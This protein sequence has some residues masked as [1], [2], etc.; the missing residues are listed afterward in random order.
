[1]RKGMILITFAW[2]VEAIGVLA[3]FVTAVITTY[4]SGVIP[5][6]IWP[7]LVALP[8]GMI[9]VAELGRIPLTSVL[10]SRHKVMQVVALLGIL[11]LAGLAFENW[12]FG[13]E[14]I[15]QLR[16]ESVTQ[17]ALALSEAQATQ[18]NLE[19]Q[20]EDIGK[21]DT[22]RREELRR[23]LATVTADIK[24]LNDEH[25]KNLESIREACR[26]V[27]GAC[28]VPRSKTEDA[29]YE[30][31]MAPKRDQRDRLQKELEEFVKKDRTKSQGL[32]KEIGEAKTKVTVAS[33]TWL[34][35]VNANQI[36]RLASFYF[37][38]APKDV[39]DQQFA[40]ARGV[41]STFSAVAISLAGTIA[42]LVYYASEK[43][44]SKYSPVGKMVAGVR[45]Y[46]AR[47]RRKTY[48][49]KYRD[50]VQY[51]DKPVPVRQPHLVLV[52]WF[53]RYPMQVSLKDGVVQLKKVEAA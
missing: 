20:R 24:A 49:L 26:L 2:T 43:P 32:D 44:R 12:T 51:V 13:F 22:S 35:E 39:T 15:V 14:R 16:L 8:M 42:A 10:F 46:V 1:M 52:P 31:A 17:A 7:W 34:A 41:F 19:S 11:V 29:R 21:D 40:A 47:K 9:A 33:K 37:R 18:K 53:I 28:I 4:P 36:Y 48:V 25:V 23:D 38:V 5:P 30:D 3:G 27:T 45:A 50:G 6:G